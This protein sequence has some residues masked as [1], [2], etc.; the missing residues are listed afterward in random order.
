MDRLLAAHR[1][2]VALS[3]VS[4]A[5]KTVLDYQLV[6]QWLRVNGCLND[7]PLVFTQFKCFMTQ[8]KFTQPFTYF[9]PKRNLLPL[10]QKP[11]KHKRLAF[12]N[13]MNKIGQD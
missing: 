11:S 13:I 10:N 2:H 7:T 8:V 3:S 5:R 12:S 6:K 4:A 9:D 1:P